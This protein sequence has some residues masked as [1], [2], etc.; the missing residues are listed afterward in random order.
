MKVIKSINHNAAIGIDSLGRELVVLGKGVGFG[1]LPREVP[2]S[3]IDRTFVGIDQKYLALIS[4]LPPEHLEFAAQFSDVVR[5]RVSQELSPNLVV[6]LADHISFMIRR[7]KEGL[8]VSMPLAYEVEHS[9]PVEYALGTVC[10][11]GVEK[12]FGVRIPKSEAVG[13]ALSIV[14]SI[15]TLGS[16]RMRSSKRVERSIDRATRIVERSFGISVDRASFDYARFATHVRYLI[17]RIASG[18]TLSTQNGL[19]YDDV[20]STYP[21]IAV[22]AVDVAK[23]ITRS[24]EETVTDEELIYLMLHI[25]RLVERASE[26]TSPKEG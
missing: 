22:C 14:N 15:V 20:V 26:G 4:E 1:E 11:R 2:L 12:T 8:Y 5:A 7:S 6:T 16:T 18:E 23:A 24:D 10:V 25:N 21:E 17:D 9:Y 19:L 3:Q 13:V